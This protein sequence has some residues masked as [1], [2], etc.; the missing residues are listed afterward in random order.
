MSTETNVYENISPEL[1]EELA[2]MLPVFVRLLNLIKMAGDAMTE[3]TAAHLTV[4][5]ERAANLLQVLDDERL[6]RLLNGLLEKGDILVSLLN[7]VT[8]LEENGT[9][10]KLLELVQALGTV[11]DALTEESVKHLTGKLLPLVETGDQLLSSSVVK[12]APQILDAVDKTVLEMKSRKTEQLSVFGLLGLLKKKEVQ[13]AV[14]FGTALLKNISN[15]Q[16]K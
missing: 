16:T 12:K 9:L 1:R 8:V 2:E 4:K 13:E 5:L 7:K 6:P 15:S 3:E 11:T 10:D 14:Q